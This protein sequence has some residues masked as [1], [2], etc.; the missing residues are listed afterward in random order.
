MKK[1]LLTAIFACLPLT[2]AMAHPKIVVP[3]I[4]WDYGNVPQNATL[5]H[6][7]VVKNIGD[8]TLRITDVKPG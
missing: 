1:V 4:H 8:D 6:D 2:S 7:Y 3:E 5:S